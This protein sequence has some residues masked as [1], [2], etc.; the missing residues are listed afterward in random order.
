M[1]SGRSG[2]A[3]SFEDAELSWPSATSSTA[4]SSRF[5]SS[6]SRSRSSA[7]SS[8]RSFVAARKLAGEDLVSLGSEGLAERVLRTIESSMPAKSGL[9]DTLPF[10]GASGR[11][12]ITGCG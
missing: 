11:G 12:G 10:R 5:A 2:L 4:A 9:Y 7:A 8:S 6:S 1:M 3:S